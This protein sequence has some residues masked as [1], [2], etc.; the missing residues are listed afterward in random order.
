[1][2]KGRKRKNTIKIKKRK[3]KKSKRRKNKDN[4]K[5]GMKSETDDNVLSR[6][7]KSHRYKPYEAHL[8]RLTD[9][10]IILDSKT[11]FDGRESWRPDGDRGILKL[12]NVDKK[13]GYLKLELREED[14]NGEEILRCTAEISSHINKYDFLSQIKSEDSTKRGYGTNLLFLLAKARNDKIVHNGVDYSEITIRNFLPEIFNPFRNLFHLSVTLWANHL[15]EESPQF[16][17]FEPFYKKELSDVV[18]ILYNHKNSEKDI[19]KYG[20]DL[21]KKDIESRMA[22]DVTELLEVMSVPPSKIF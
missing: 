7:V 17:L 18:N 5:A 9:P 3:T 15:L 11:E 22:D 1:M 10:I 8:S 20:E 13:R 14:I 4:I 6:L 19:E 16:T 21:A 12:Y 2:S